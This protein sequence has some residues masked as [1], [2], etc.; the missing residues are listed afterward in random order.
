MTD[1]YSP[2]ETGWAGA[3]DPRAEDAEIAAA[4]VKETASGAAMPVTETRLETEG[5]AASIINQEREPTAQALDST[6][7]TLHRQAEN[8]PAGGKMAHVTHSAADKLDD[9]AAYV[10]GHEVQDVMTDLRHFVTSHPSQSIAAAATLG[11][12]VGRVF[13]HR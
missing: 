2:D 6:A 13:R 1:G 9:A 5:S 8:M 3:T 7:A 12:L 11:F 4:I 10:R